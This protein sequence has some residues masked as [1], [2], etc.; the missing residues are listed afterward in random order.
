MNTYKSEKVVIVPPGQDAQGHAFSPPASH[1]MASGT[2]GLVLLEERPRTIGKA[3]CLERIPHAD[4]GLAKGRLR[5]YGFGLSSARARIV[6][7]AG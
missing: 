7:L 2:G 3:S 4:S 5:R 1:E 6:A